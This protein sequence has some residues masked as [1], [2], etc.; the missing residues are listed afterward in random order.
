[1][2]LFVFA[3]LIGVSFVYFVLFF[4]KNAPKFRFSLRGVLGLVAIV[5]IF[6]ACTIGYRR[7]FMAQLTWI[8]VEKEDTVKLFPPAEK[9]QKSDDGRF[10]FVYYARNRSIQHLIAKSKVRNYVVTEEA[11]RV[12][13]E[14]ESEAEDLL[15]LIQKTDTLP[16]GALTIRGKLRDSNGNPVSGS[17]IDILGGFQFINCFRTRDDGTFT[18]ALSD[19]DPKVPVGTALYFRVRSPMDSADNP[20]R[21]NSGYFFLDSS[22]PVS[23]LD[24]QIPN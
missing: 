14:D 11:V 12:T 17:T 19:R 21:W 15:Q 2:V 13:T 9:V 10:E 5:A 16:A 20:R 3:C 1:M 24:I 6:L 22:N 8:P 7:N 23:L 18:M 4:R